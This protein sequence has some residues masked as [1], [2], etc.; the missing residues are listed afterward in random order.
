MTRSRPG[1]RSG[2]FHNA[3]VYEKCLRAQIECSWEQ[4]MT[5]AQFVAMFQARFKGGPVAALGESDYDLMC[6]AGT[7][8]VCLCVV[9]FP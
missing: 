8:G 5:Q 7:W 3:Q 2:L 6:R 4:A 9:S 1:R